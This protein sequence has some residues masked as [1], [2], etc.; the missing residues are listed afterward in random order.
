MQPRVDDRH[1]GPVPKI[2]TLN[3]LPEIVHAIG[4]LPTSHRVS[5]DES[6]ISHEVK[7]VVLHWSKEKRVVVQSPEILQTVDDRLFV[8]ASRLKAAHVPV[9]DRLRA[10][11]RWDSESVNERRNLERHRLEVQRRR[12]DRPQMASAC[13][14]P[15]WKTITG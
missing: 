14:P 5:V 8:D 1:R 3:G 13:S 9:A 2:R 10:R 12:G 6:T 15:S 11:Q 7:E 4:M